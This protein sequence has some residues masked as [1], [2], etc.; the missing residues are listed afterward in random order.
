MA[1]LA[2]GFAGLA[3]FTIASF[4]L[5]LPVAAAIG[6]GFI[7]L[8]VCNLSPKLSLIVLLTTICF[9]PHWWGVEVWGYL[10]V[11]T[12]VTLAI[13]PGALI[14]GLQGVDRGIVL[15]ASLA[16]FVVLLVVSGVS[17]PGHGFV[18]VIQ[19]VPAALAGYALT[20]QA[21][22]EFVR[23]AVTVIFTAVAICVLIESYADWNPY[24][25]T[26]TAA[27]QY[28]A[29]TDLQVRGGETRSEWSFGHAI[30]LANSLALAIPMVL[31]SRFRTLTQ[32]LSIALIVGAIVTTFTRSALVTATLGVVLTL[33][34]LRGQ[35]SR[36]VHITIAVLT[37]AAVALV[38]PWVEGVYTAASAETTR[39]GAGRLRLLQLIPYLNTFGTASGYHESHGIFE[40]FG[41]VTIDNAFLRLA[42][43]FGWLFGGLCLIAALLVFIRAVLGRA[44][45][46]EIALA[47]VV[48][49]LLT[50]SLITQF[51][52]LV[53]F[54]IGVAAATARRSTKEQP[55][56]T[57]PR[58]S[59]PIAVDARRSS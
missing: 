20:R 51:A 47:S 36:R 8:I 44:S 54:F 59:N 28:L 33:W 14:R 18:F 22:P 30:A 34:T 43:N 7:A 57:S 16:A 53:W 19:W 12:I 21:G 39:S 26:M 25:G 29:I 37:V 1:I 49:A 50:V 55:T 32:T 9:I 41:T 31:T 40:W 17:M 24:S 35:V 5:S 38:L 42:V 3:L 45:A 23:D 46:P 2:T 58:L 10:P 13:L 6:F 11:A 15:V 56:S 27:Q 52:I 48:P 4:A